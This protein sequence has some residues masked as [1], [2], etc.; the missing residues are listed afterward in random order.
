MVESQHPRPIPEALRLEA[1]V[2]ADAAQVRF[3]QR[4]FELLQGNEPKISL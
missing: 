2:A 4:W 1:H 3:R